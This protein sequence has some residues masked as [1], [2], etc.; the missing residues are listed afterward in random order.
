ALTFKYLFIVVISVV[1]AGVPPFLASRV[2]FV[3]SWRNRQD[4]SICILTSLGHAH[5]SYV[6]SDSG[7][8]LKS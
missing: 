5:C 3:T 2:L 8:L 6:A 7:S 4:R 1:L